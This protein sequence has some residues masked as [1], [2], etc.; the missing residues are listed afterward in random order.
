M[1]KG[2]T[3]GA[4]DLLHAGHIIML[5]EIR[6]QCDHL[7][8]GLQSDPSI[9]RSEKSK[10]IETLEERIIRLEGCKY[11]DEIIIYDTE[12]D[13]YELLK[14]LNPDFRFIGADW[15]GKSFTGEDLPIKTIF[16]TRRHNYS[17]TNLR[18]RI[19]DNNI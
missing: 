7:I 12:K 10:P 14:K 6:S 11:V 19:L 9:D 3:C 17:S 18:K 1:K 15:E 13:L 5:K 8:V 2:F 4:F 16:N